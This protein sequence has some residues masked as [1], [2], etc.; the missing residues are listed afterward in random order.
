MT[1]MKAPSPGRND[2]CHCGSGKKYKR[3]HIEEDRAKDSDFLRERFRNPQ[4]CG[5][6]QVIIYEPEDPGEFERWQCRVCKKETFWCGMCEDT[7]ET[8]TPSE[9]CVECGAETAIASNAFWHPGEKGCGCKLDGLGIDKG[10][11]YTHF[12]RWHAPDDSPEHRR[13]FHVVIGKARQPPDFGATYEDISPDDIDAPIDP[14]EEDAPATRRR[15]A[16]K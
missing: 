11:V 9:P 6:P 1:I 8:I 13:I 16:S 10:D 12:E 3:C 14:D 15:F 7:H 5:E 4:H 2:P